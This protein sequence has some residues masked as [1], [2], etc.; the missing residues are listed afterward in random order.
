M[1]YSHERLKE[2][3]LK[4]KSRG[5]P[6]LQVETLGEA[7]LR[8]RRF[9]STG[10]AERWVEMEAFPVRSIR[11]TAGSGDW[12]T[13]GFI[14][15]AG[16]GGVD[17]F[18]DMSDRELR[19]ALR[20]G[21]ALSAWNCGYEGAAG[22]MYA[23]KRLAFDEQVREILEGLD[24]GLESYPIPRQAEF[25][26]MGPSAR[27]ALRP[28]QQ[29]NRPEQPGRDI[30]RRHPSLASPALNCFKFV[31]PLVGTATGPRQ[32][33]DMHCGILGHHPT[34]AAGKILVGRR[35]LQRRDGGGGNQTDRHVVQLGNGVVRPAR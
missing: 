23:T 6:R 32:D 35:L 16:R 30:C 34:V 27:P 19:E 22:G 25:P 4:S 29:V 15:R 33:M 28:I 5:I 26:T 20:F 8:Y 1:K 31:I 3:C 12:C 14:D 24:A 17:G 7:G 13:A 2:N 21:Q 11:D 9:S 10:R 18:S